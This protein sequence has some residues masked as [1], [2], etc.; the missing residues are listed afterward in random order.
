MSDTMENPFVTLLRETGF[1]RVKLAAVLD[2]SV[3]VISSL[4]TGG[5][6]RVGKRL[7]EGMNSK[8]FD[9]AGIAKAYDEWRKAM[10]EINRT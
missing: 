3:S 2:V 7:I 6:R 9:G 4:V 5:Q 10:G 1:S 8:G